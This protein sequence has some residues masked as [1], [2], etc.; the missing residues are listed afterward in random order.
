MQTKSSNENCPNTGL[1]YW[2]PF[3]F[4]LVRTKHVFGFQNLIWN[5]I[6]K[7]KDKTKKWVPSC[8]YVWNHNQ[9]QIYV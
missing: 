4:E 1:N 5:L 6:F 7:I 3:Q 8:I 9:N 2:F